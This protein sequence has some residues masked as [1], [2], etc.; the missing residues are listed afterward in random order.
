VLYEYEQWGHPNDPLAF[1]YMLSY[2]PYENIEAK[3]YPHMLVK[4]GLNDLQVPFWD[5]AKWVV[6][7]RAHKTDNNRLLLTNMSAG[8]VAHRAGMTNYAKMRK[9]TLM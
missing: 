9:C 5:P 8:H 2:S 6:R 1:D 4:A 7:L 3:S